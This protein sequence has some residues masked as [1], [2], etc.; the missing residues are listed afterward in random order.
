MLTVARRFA[1]STALA[2]NIAHALGRASRSGSW[3]RCLCPI[4]GGNALALKDGDRGGVIVHCHAGCQRFEIY[5]ELRRLGLLDGGR[6]IGANG[7]IGANGTIGTGPEDRARR[8]AEALAPWNDARPASGTVVERYWRS[9]GLLGQIPP[10][11]RLCGMFHRES[12]ERRPAMLSLVEHVEHGR[13]AVLATYLAIDGS[14]KASI[15]P[16]RKFFGPVGGGAVRLGSIRDG[17]WLVIGEGI[18]STASAMQLWNIPSGWAALS[19]G[20]IRN[21]VLPPEA[22]QIVLAA[23]HDENRVGQEAAIDAAWLWRQ[24]GRTVRIVLPPKPDTDFNDVIRGDF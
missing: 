24:E 20:G 8:I 12:G 21:L 5:A 1:A 13:V 11:I 6:P 7:S 16:N 23:D 22:Q 17:D 14:L 15:T 10:T 3:W 2:E 4:H 9:R 19:A 18:E